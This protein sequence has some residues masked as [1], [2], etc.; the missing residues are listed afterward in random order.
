MTINN[1]LA[2]NG[3]DECGNGVGGGDRLK[4]RRGWRWS[5]CHFPAVDSGRRPWLMALRGVAVC[6]TMSHHVY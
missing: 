6:T 5:Y 4:G 3:G 1:P 2:S